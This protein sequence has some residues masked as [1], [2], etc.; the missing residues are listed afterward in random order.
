ML[1][2]FRRDV[3]VRVHRMVRR[4][5]RASLLRAKGRCWCRA[6]RGR[7]LARWKHLRAHRA[8]RRL[9]RSARQSRDRDN[10]YR[11]NRSEEFPMAK[12]VLQSKR[13]FKWAPP[14][15]HGIEVSKGRL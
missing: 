4:R 8:R 12:R 10:G 14:Y 2:Q 5:A 3:E 13:A 9:F 11:L 6:E 1:P 15:V 7:S